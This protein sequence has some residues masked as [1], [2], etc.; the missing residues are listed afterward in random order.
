MPE[1]SKSP[2]SPQSFT[3][4]RLNDTLADYQQPLT[5]VQMSW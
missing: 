2:P 3:P 4:H 5:D 1:D